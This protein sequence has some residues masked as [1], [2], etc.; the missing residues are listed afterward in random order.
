M[1]YDGITTMLI[2]FVKRGNKFF[3][4][5]IQGKIMLSINHVSLHYTFVHVSVVSISSSF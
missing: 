1:T 5:K 4:L 2:G 3:N